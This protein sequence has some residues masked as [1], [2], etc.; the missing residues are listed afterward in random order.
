[1]KFNVFIKTALFFSALVTLASCDIG[2]DSGNYY[3]PNPNVAFGLVANASPS[4]GD[5]YFFAD[6][7]RINNQGPLNYGSLAGYFNFVTGNRTLSLRNTNGET[8]ASADVTLNQGEYFSVFAVNTFDNIELAVYNDSLAQ[9]AANT[10]RIRFINLSPDADAINIEGTSQNFAENLEFKDATGF[11]S[12]SNG[13]YEFTFTDSETGEELLTTTT[14]L[15]A[16]RA[17]TIFTKGFVSPPEGSNETFTT[18][19]IRHY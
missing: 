9:P 6:D 15:L 19:E 5:L 16:G 2:D 17:Y 18:Q 14:S 12:I 8:L 11:T 3:E 7:N 1:M 13:T 10:A 4:S